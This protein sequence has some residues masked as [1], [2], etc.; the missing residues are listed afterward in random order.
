MDGV[1]DNDDVGAGLLDIGGSEPSSD[2]VLPADDQPDEKTRKIEEL[3]EKL[4]STLRRVEELER[5]AGRAELANLKLSA[6]KG[7]VRGSA[8]GVELMAEMAK[9][10]GLRRYG[11]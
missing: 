9:D 7:G 8:S 2:G 3:T 10:G 11:H 6:S 5:R 1:I 4:A